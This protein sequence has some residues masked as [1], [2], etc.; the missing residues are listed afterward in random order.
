MYSSQLILPPSPT[1]FGA[2]RQNPQL[3]LK[4][5]QITTICAKGCMKMFSPLKVKVWGAGY[6]TLLDES[7]TIQV[8]KA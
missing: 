2:G 8:H 3:C 6:G 4:V 5:L 7:H 1:L